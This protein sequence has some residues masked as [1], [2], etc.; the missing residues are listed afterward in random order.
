MSAH[1]FAVC[2]QAWRLQLCVT[3][4]NRISLLK[5]RPYE[6]ISVTYLSRCEALSVHSLSSRVT[7][8][9]R[10]GALCLVCLH[11]LMPSRDSPIAV[12]S[13]QCAQT[14][15]SRGELLWFGAHCFV[16]RKDFLDRV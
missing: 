11:M 1:A 13:A 9:V 4:H 7:D 5:H 15:K 6:F 2:P 8:F 10:F 14:E 12:W 16:Y 3:K